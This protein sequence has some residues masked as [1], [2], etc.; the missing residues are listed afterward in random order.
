MNLF[1]Y[2]SNNI[3]KYFKQVKSLKYI[4]IIPFVI[5][6]FVFTSVITFLS[7]HNAQQS[8]NYL[9]NQLL[10]EIGTRVEN[11]F[12]K[13]ISQINLI[14]QINAEGIQLEQLNPNDSFSLTQYLWKQLL[15]L[16]DISYIYWGDRS[17]NFYGVYRLADNT[18]GYS[19]SNKSRNEKNYFFRVLEDGSRG[20]YLQN[21]KEFDPRI[22]PW[23]KSAVAN[24]SQIWTPIYTEYTTKKRTIS[25]AY[26]IFENGSIQGVIGVDIIFD[27]L[28]DFFSRLKVGKNG[29]VLVIN[30]SGEI[31]M[32]SKEGQKFVKY[33]EDK[34]NQKSNFKISN[35]NDPLIVALNKFI[36]NQFKDIKNIT[37]SKQLFLKVN[38]QTQ[39]LYLT[40][41]SDNNGLNWTI[42]VAVPESDFMAQINANTRNTILLCGLGLI[43][44]I[45]I[46]ILTAEWIN[47]AILKVIKSAKLLADGYLSY[48]IKID[49]ADELGQLANSFNIMAKQLEISVLEIKQSEQRLANF[50]EAMPIGVFVIDENDSPYYANQASDRILGKSL[51]CDCPPDRLIETYQLYKAGTNQLYP[52]H[53][54]PILVALRNG[55]SVTIE[56]MEVHKDDNEKILL[57]V[58]GSP[59]LGNNRNIEFA[60]VAF[61][62]ITKRK[63]IENERI[64]FTAE[65]KTKNDALK[66]ARGQLEEYN[67]T[68]EEKVKERTA[69]L[70]AAQKQIIAEQNLKDLGRSV[71]G[72]CHEV[73]N[74]MQSIGSLSEGCLSL[75]AKISKEIKSLNLEPDRLNKTQNRIDK[76]SKY[77]KTIDDY[78]HRASTILTT[79]LSQVNP[80]NEFLNTPTNLNLKENNHHELVN[81]NNFINSVFKIIA[82]SKRQEK[83]G[84]KLKTKINLDQNI[85]KVSIPTIEF[86]QI[87]TNL[88]YNACDAAMLQKEN[89]NKIDDKNDFIPTV[90][91]STKLLDERVEIIISDNGVGISPEISS[92]LFEPFVTSKRQGKGTGLGLYISQKLVEKNHGKIYWFRENL[93][94]K[95]IVLLPI[96]S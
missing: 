90:S 13:Y 65:L 75:S 64:S 29:Q 25:S 50:L 36:K 41:I 18:L 76:L 51:I 35:N 70:E 87:F 79:M 84:D 66:L 91:L 43:I 95:F 59:I 56:D 19:I 86:S 15:K 78:T 82:Y 81:F 67:K 2:I 9:A 1:S 5:Q 89:L 55:K 68:L 10:S 28:Y 74:P 49:R 21:P 24:K 58:F 4:I 80:K 72:I 31:V 52:N 48:R 47:A 83:L 77:L 17:G 8:I 71:A 6:I 93:E 39:Y 26:P 62:D 42:V 92:Q 37:S 30:D 11:R 60:I 14:L 27:Q 7:F 94:T 3:K 45:C 46:G 44:S 16:P 73:N 32:S 34:Q 12:Q 69:Q 38:N 23:Y 63:E 96:E 22:R 20:D 40:P 53:L 57:Q 33:I 85:H 54:N 88:I 61:F